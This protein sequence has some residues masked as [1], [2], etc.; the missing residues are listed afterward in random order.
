MEFVTVRHPEIEGT[1]EVSRDAFDVVYAEKGWE[2]V[3]E[4]TSLTDGVTVV[5]ATPAAKRSQKSEA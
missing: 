1:A 5:P 2:V 4:D 3:D